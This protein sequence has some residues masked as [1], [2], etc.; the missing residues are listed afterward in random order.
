MSEEAKKIN[1]KPPKGELI[2]I[3]IDKAKKAGMNLLLPSIHMEGLS[4]FHSPVLDYCELSPEISDG[5]VYFH[6]ESK[7]L[8]PSK[9]GLMK[10]AMCA[11]IMW[12]MSRTGRTDDRK[13]RDYVSYSACGAVRRIDGTLVHFPAEY[14]MD[15][16]VI[17][18]KLRDQYTKKGKSA[19]KTGDEL[20]GYI[21]YCVKRDLL[22]KREHKL[23][24]CESGAMTR[25][26]R[27]LLG[28][29]AGYTAQE[30][31]KPFVVARIVFRPD[32]SDPEIRKIMIK[33]SIESITGI[34]GGVDEDVNEQISFTPI[35]IPTSDFDNE[36]PPDPETPDN[37]TSEKAD[38]LASD[39]QTK[40]TTLE[41][42]AKRADYDL[43]QIKKPL[44]KFT[45][46]ELEGFF[47]K[48]DALLDIP[49]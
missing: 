42:M 41:T 5:D 15:F 39:N 7:K 23:K 8:V 28:L 9:Q 29:K 49:F 6:S 27:S 19:K 35:D 4:E 13:S 20:H 21:D 48:L 30:L 33:K 12:D 47:D 26:I 16:A 17:E 38:F 44:D 43:K 18:E 32:Y 31:K 37:L 45:E 1:E 2:N 25:V 34:Y 3:E 36:D 10:L 24:I 46:E 14:D 11:G 40:I 22:Y